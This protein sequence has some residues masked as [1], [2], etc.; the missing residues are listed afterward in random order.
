MMDLRSVIFLYL[1]PLCKKQNKKGDEEQLLGDT[2]DDITSEEYISET[3]SV[4]VFKHSEDSYSTCQNQLIVHLESIQT[5]QRELQQYNA[6][7]YYQHYR[8][9]NIE[10][11]QSFTKAVNV[12]HFVLYF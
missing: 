6:I 8:F 9:V 2:Q 1:E 5:W 7:E 10:H 4:E 12:I 11:I 3:Q